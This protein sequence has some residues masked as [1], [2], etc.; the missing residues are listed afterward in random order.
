[1]PAFEHMKL[2]CIP[3]CN[4]QC[5]WNRAHSAIDLH[6]RSEKLEQWRQLI[7]MSGAT[8]HVCLDDTK[9]PQAFESCIAL[10]NGP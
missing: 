10:H 2:R 1:M 9:P 3:R 4:S 8:M 5:W 6:R 7:Y